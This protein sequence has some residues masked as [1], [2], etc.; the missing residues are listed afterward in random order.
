MRPKIQPICTVISLLWL[1]LMIFIF[2]NA[3]SAQSPGSQTSS[4]VNGNSSISAPFKG[5]LITI[6]TTNRLA[7]GINS[8]SWNHTEFLDNPP[9]YLRGIGGNVVLD[10]MGF[11]D[12]PNEGGSRVDY[13]RSTSS[14]KL[15]S[16]H[17]NGNV[18]DFS[19]RMAFFLAP[20]ETDPHCG[21]A[22][23]ATEPSNYIL[24]RHVTI[25]AQGLPNAIE[26]KTSITSPE[27]RQ[28]G[29]FVPVGVHGANMFTVFYS[30][31]PTTR[32]LSD[33]SVT[34]GKQARSLIPVVVSTPDHNLALGLYAP[35]ISPGSN[36]GTSKASYVIGNFTDKKS[37]A[38]KL[39]CDFYRQPIQPITYS[40]T[41]YL[42]VGNLSD[43]TDGI[44]ALNAKLAGKP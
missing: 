39:N 38:T 22:R 8:L 27:N 31:D 41:C 6:R 5:S 20:G 33:M 16:L 14:S 37:P 9:E 19:K 25:G 24:S 21:A 40:F 32:R 3:T 43:V 15:L 11:C 12:N 18:L 34:S 4:T 26:F 44:N 17:A 13:F 10:R 1:L 28:N 2:P 23:G 30:Y 42:L 29:Y 36:T 35:T 7:G